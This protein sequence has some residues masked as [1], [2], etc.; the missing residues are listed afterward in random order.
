MPRKEAAAEVHHQGSQDHIE[1]TTDASLPAWIRETIQAA[2]NDGRRQ[3]WRAAFGEDVDC[4]FDAGEDLVTVEPSV[5]GESDPMCPFRTQG[6]S[7]AA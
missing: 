3:P 6:S 7:L 5:G 1:A 4:R 2:Q